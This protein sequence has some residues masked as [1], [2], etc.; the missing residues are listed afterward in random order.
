MRNEGAKSKFVLLLT[1]ICK[2]F[3]NPHN[4]ILKNLKMKLSSEFLFEETFM[5][6]LFT[7]CFHDKNTFHLA[8]TWMDQNKYLHVYITIN[9]KRNVRLGKNI[10]KKKNNNQYSYDLKYNF[11][12]VWRFFLLLEKLQQVHTEACVNFLREKVQ[13]YRANQIPLKLEY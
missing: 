12:N 7:T 4:L 5:D 6:T 10:A 3:Q 2:L 1:C 11:Y 9:F 13:L 8:F